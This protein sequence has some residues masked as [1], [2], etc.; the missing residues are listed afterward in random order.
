MDDNW[1][2]S[3]QYSPQDVIDLRDALIDAVVLLGEFR[4]K[5]N[6]Y[7]S[8]ELLSKADAFLAPHAL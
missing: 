1:V 3:G 7:V 6:N 4:R 8:P 5:A 2:D